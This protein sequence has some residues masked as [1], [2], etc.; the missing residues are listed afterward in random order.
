M[1]DLLVRYCSTLSPP[2][3]KSLH[4]AIV[5]VEITVFNEDPYRLASVFLLIT[6]LQATVHTGINVLVGYPHRLATVLC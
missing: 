6:C 3:W 2:K 4:Q 5:H 1:E